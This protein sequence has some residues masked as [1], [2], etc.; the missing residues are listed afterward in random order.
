[1]TILYPPPD[2]SGGPVGCLLLLAGATSADT[3]GR[4]GRRRGVRRRDQPGTF[5]AALR[6]RRAHRRTAPTSPA[7]GRRCRGRGDRGEPERRAGTSTGADV[8]RGAA[9]AARRL[10]LAT[11]DALPPASG[12][13]E[14]QCLAQGDLLRVARRAARGQIA[15]AEV[16]LNRARQP[17]LPADASAAS[18]T[19]AA[20]SPTS[21]T[22]YSDTMRSG[23]ARARSEKLAQADARR[24]AAHADRRG[25]LFPHPLGAPG[26]VAAL[27]PHRRRSATTCSTGRPPG[28]P[29]AEGPL[30]KGTRGRGAPG[31]PGAPSSFRRRRDAAVGSVS[32]HMR[33]HRRARCCIPAPWR[34][35]SP[36][37][38][39]GA[40]SGL[41]IRW[42]AREG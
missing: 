18:P 17:Q 29:E 33:H 2:A 23:V 26:L 24:A 39:W 5:H 12:D 30:S 22:A 3:A 35:E 32:Y 14:W 34:L 6:E 42:G 16:V 19:R 21:A 15:V 31:L 40:P 9:I 38:R 1:M 10:D 4:Q 28:S 8:A 36:P 27:R 25:A 41:Q 11:L 7:R 20:S 13:A 37:I